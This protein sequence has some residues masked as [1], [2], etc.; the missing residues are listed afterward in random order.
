MKN[1]NTYTHNST[2]KKKKAKNINLVLHITNKYFLYTHTYTPHIT[3]NFCLSIFDSI[4]NA[5]ATFR[6]YVYVCVLLD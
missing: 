4:A 3:F 2:K 1:K 5:S 6:W